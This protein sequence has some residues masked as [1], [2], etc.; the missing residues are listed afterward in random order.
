MPTADTIITTT[1]PATTTMNEPNAK[2]VP[3]SFQPIGVIP[4]G[5]RFAEQTPV[6][7]VYA[8]GCV[9]RAE[10]FP[11]YREGLRDLDG[12][13]HIFLLLENDGQA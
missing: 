2:F 4:N 9:G 7:P 3:V 13:S 1:T 5:Y 6:Q 10:I 8:R 11:A 12:F